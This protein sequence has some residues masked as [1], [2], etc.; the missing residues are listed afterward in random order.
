MATAE[1]RLAIIESRLSDLESK[2]R[3]ISAGPGAVITNRP[4]LAY[5]TKRTTGSRR[6]SDVQGLARER[7]VGIKQEDLQ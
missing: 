4:D 5:D 3:N 6:R 1:E 7:L 2:V